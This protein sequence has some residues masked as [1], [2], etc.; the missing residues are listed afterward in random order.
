MKAKRDEPLEEIWAI[1]RQIAKQFA[2]DPPKRVAYYQ[3]KQKEGGAKIYRPD[4]LV[5]ADVQAYDALRE[6]AHAQIA[7]GQFT[8]LTSY[9]AA[10]KGKGKAKG[11][12]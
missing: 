3:R 8:T 6:S 10:R 2:G 11:A 12:K 9:R 4:E 5:G 7:A 1:R